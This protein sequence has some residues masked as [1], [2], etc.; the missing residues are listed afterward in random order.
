LPRL[1][2]GRTASELPLTPQTVF[3]VTASLLFLSDKFAF[4]PERNAWV[5]A[6][7]A[8]TKAAYLVLVFP[9]IQRGGRALFRRLE[10]RKSRSGGAGRGE[11]APL[12]RRKTG[13]RTVDEANHFDVSWARW[14]RP[15]QTSVVA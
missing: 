4:D 15:P 12:I 14:L 13:D 11:R 10:A 8:F 3:I 7:I 6:Y 9:L 1:R 5:L 2:L